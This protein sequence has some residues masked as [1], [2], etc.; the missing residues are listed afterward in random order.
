MKLFLIYKFNMQSN[1]YDRN[2][3][4]ALPS[5]NHNYTKACKYPPP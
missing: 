4:C 2:T 1:L 5:R 3:E